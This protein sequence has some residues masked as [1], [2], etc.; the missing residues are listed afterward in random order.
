MLLISSKQEGDIGGQ[1]VEYVKDCFGISTNDH[2]GNPKEFPAKHKKLAKP[3]TSC[4]AAW[5]AHAN[6]EF[7]HVGVVEAVEYGPHA[8]GAYK[9]KRF[10]C[11]N[12]KG[13]EV[14]H[15]QMNKSLS[16]LER[17]GGTGRFLG[18]FEILL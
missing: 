7:G 8:T 1:C 14:V 11:S 3:I 5:D 17:D 6:N 13:D 15:V 4:I 12:R 2:I 16:E 10:S 9:I 18:Y